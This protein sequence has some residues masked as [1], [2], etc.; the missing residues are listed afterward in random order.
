M[1]ASR[2]DVMLARGV[3]PTTKAALYQLH[4]DLFETDEVA[5]M[6]LKRDLRV[7]PLLDTY[8]ETTLSSVR[9]HNPGRGSRPFVVL[10]CDPATAQTLAERLG[11]RLLGVSEPTPVSAEKLSGAHIHISDAGGGFSLPPLESTQ[12]PH[13]TGATP[14]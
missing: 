7:K 10:V 1:V 4:P 2:L 12:E 6:W 8:R 11:A 13:K 5:G 9:L 14:D 3:V